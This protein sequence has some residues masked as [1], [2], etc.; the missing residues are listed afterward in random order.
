MKNF[1]EDLPLS[2]AHLSDLHT[3]PEALLETAGWRSGR[4]ST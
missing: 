4:Y 3:E 2:L 1:P